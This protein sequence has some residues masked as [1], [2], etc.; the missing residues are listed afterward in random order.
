MTK[1]NAHISPD[2][3]GFLFADGTYEVVRIYRGKIFRFEDHLRRLKRSLNEIRIALDDLENLLEISDRLIRDNALDTSDAI[4]YIQITRGVAPRNHRFPKTGTPPTVYVTAYPAE[5]PVVKWEKGVKVI[6]LPDIRWTRCD[7]KSVSLLPNVL[8][9]QTAMEHDADEAVFVRD[10]VI[11]E[12]THTNF[13]AIQDGTLWTHPINNL[14]LDGI[15]RDVILEICPELG[16]P[17]REKPIPES[18][19]KKMDECLILGSTTEVM[20]VV[21]I[22]DTQ[23]GNGVPG[24]LTRKLQVAFQKLTRA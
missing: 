10:G 17:V 1:E 7:I 6:L 20:P 18:R 21:R 8:A 11:T 22:D 5:P 4:L 16:I 3:R 9:N 24:K 14:V 2:D 23:I 15:T 13:A 12:G 19:V